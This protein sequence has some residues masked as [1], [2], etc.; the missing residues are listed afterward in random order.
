M[1]GAEG[2]RAYLREA[3]NEH[4]RGEAHREARKAYR[5]ALRIAGCNALFPEHQTKWPFPCAQLCDA[6]GLLRWA[7]DAT[8]GDPHRRLSAGTDV[9]CSHCGGSRF[10][11]LQQPVIADALVASEVYDR[12]ARRRFARRIG[13][14]VA[15]VALGALASFVAAS[16]LPA[17]GALVGLFSLAGVSVLANG[18]R[19]DLPKRRLPRRWSMVLPP[20]GERHPIASGVVRAETTLVAPL[21]GRPCVAYEIAVRHDANPRAEPST[22]GL[23]EQRSAGLEVGRMHVGANALHLDLPREVLRGGDPARVEQY[24]RERGVDPHAAEL[25]I[26]ETI[27][28]PGAYLQLQVGARGALVATH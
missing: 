1:G 23:V 26:Y 16:A 12:G 28:D 8:A 14:S 27:V 13:G 21:S 22:W 6:C 2:V 20:R 25:V 18:D 5:R 15:L 7:D 11:D 9:R 24:L 10:I 17:F 19:I 3:R 4:S